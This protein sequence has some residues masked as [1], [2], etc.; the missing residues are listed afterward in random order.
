MTALAFNRL[1]RALAIA[2]CKGYLRRFFK[3]F[4]GHS[5]VTFCSIV[6]A[7][8]QRSN[9]RLTWM[10]N[11][12]IKKFQHPWPDFYTVESRLKVYENFPVS[13]DPLPVPFIWVQASNVVYHR[14]CVWNK[15]LEQSNFNV[16]ISN[17]ITVIIIVRLYIFRLQNICCV[18]VTSY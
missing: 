12:C 15:V 1:T 16:H 10:N 2:T 3:L 6:W 13:R 4:F 5:S 11:L 8:A 9:P 14:Y 7:F 17:I 18:C